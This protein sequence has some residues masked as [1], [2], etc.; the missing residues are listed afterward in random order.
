MLF[1]SRRM[2]SLAV[3]LLLLSFTLPALGQRFVRVFPNLASVLAS[4][5]SNADTNVTVLGYYTANDRGGSDITWAAGDATA[6]NGVTVFTSTHPTAQAGRWKRLYDGQINVLWSGAKRDNLTEVAT[7]WNNCFNVLSSLGGGELFVPVGTYFSA[8]T[9]G[10]KI[11]LT[12]SNIRVRAEPGTVISTHTQT[13]TSVAFQ[14]N[15]DGGIAVTNVQVSGITFLGATNSSGPASYGLQVNCDSSSD[16]CRDITISDCS[17]TLFATDGFSVG[18]NAGGFPRN[19][20]FNR[21]LAESNLRHGLGF[22]QVNGATINDS[23]FRFNRG[24][25]LGLSDGVDVEPDPGLQNLNIV[26]NRC[27]FNNNSSHGLDVKRGNG[28]EPLDIVVNDSLAFSNGGDGFRFLDVLRGGLYGSSGWSNTTHGVVL[29]SCVAFNV[30]GGS[31]YLNLGAGAQVASSRCAVS[32]ISAYS[33][34]THGIQLAGAGTSTTLCEFNTISGNFAATNTLNGILLGGAGWNKVQGNTVVFNQQEGL[35][36]SLSSQHNDIEDNDVD[37]NGQAGPDNAIDNIRFASNSSWNSLIGGHVRKS[38]RYNIGTA[39]GGGAASITLANGAADMDS[40]YV[41]HLVYTLSGT[42]SGQSRTISAYVGATRVAT[43]SLGW[44]VVPD[45]T[46][47]YEIAGAIRPRAGIGI[48]ATN[49]IGNRI[50]LSDAYYGGQTADLF[51]QGTSTLFLMPVTGDGFRVSAT[52]ANFTLEGGHF[53]VM[54]NYFINFLQPDGIYNP[55]VRM[56]GPH[57]YLQAYTGGDAYLRANAGAGSPAREIRVNALDGRLRYFSGTPL[58][59]QALN[60]SGEFMPVTVSPSSAFDTNTLTLT[61]SGGGATNAYNL[62]ED[63]GIALTARTTINFV[64]AGVSAADSGGKTV[65][66]ISGGGSGATINPTDGFLPYRFDATTFSNSP[67]YRTGASTVALSNLVQSASLTK[68]ITTLTGASTTTDWLLSDEFLLTLTADSTNTHSNVPSATATTRAVYLSVIGNGT[69]TIDFAVPGGITTNWTTSYVRTPRSGVT[70]FAFTSRGAVLDIAAS[71]DAYATTSGQVYRNSGTNGFGAIDLSDPDAVTGSLPA[72]SISGGQPYQLLRG[73]FDGLSAWDNSLLYSNANNTISAVMGVAKRGRTGDATGT[74][75]STGILGQYRFGGWN[76][77]SFV[78]GGGVDGYATENWTATANGTELRFNVVSNTTAVTSLAMTIGQDRKVKLESASTA[79]S[80]I[81]TDGNGFLV[82]TNAASGGG[83]AAEAW[84][85]IGTGTDFTYSGT[86]WERVAFGTSGPAFTLT[87][88]GTYQVIINL[89]TIDGSVA[90]TSQDFFVTNITDSV[91]VGGTFHST[92]TAPTSGD[93][94]LVIPFQI[95]TSGANRVIEVWGK[96]INGSPSNASVISTNT[97]LNVIRLDNLAGS[98]GSG[99]G[100][101]VGPSSA[102]DNAIVRFDGTTG[103]LGQNSLVTIGD[104]GAIT[105][106]DGSQTS[107]TFTPNLS[108]A[109]D[110]DIIFSNNLIT[111]GGSLLLQSSGVLGFGSRSE[112]V[113]GTDGYFTIRNEAG[114]DFEMLRFGGSTTAFPGL[115]RT[116]AELAVMLADESAFSALRASTVYVGPTN[117]AGELALKVPTATTITIAGTANE[118][119]SSAGA[120]DLSANRTWTLSLPATIDLGGKTSFELPNAAAPVVDA[121]G[122]IAGDDDLWAASRGAPVF[123]DGTA[124]VGLVGALVSDVPSNG[125]VPTW[126]TGGTITWETPAGGAGDNWGASGTTNSTLA[127]EAF[128]YDL[129]ATNNITVGGKIRAANGT[130][131]NPSILFT[132]DD[133]GS[134]NGF[135]RSAANRIGVSPAGTIALDFRNTGV[136]LVSGLYYAIN[137]DSY[138]GRE[139]AAVW[140]LGIDGASP[141]AQTIKGSDGGG[142]NIAGGDTTFGAGRSTGT[143]NRGTPKVAVGT[144][145]TGSGSGANAYGT[146]LAL[147]G[148]LKV[149]TTTTGNVD[150][151]EDDLISY[152][153]PAAQLSKDGDYFEFDVFGTFAANA[154]SAQ[155][156]F[157][158]DGLAFFDSTS[159]IFNGLT[160]RGTGKIIR[161]SAT[162][163]KI[164]GDF[165]ISGTLLGALTTTTRYYSADTSTLTGTIV[166][167]AT[168]TDTGG[169]PADNKVV[170]EGMILKQYLGQ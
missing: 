76:A 31:Y 24:H 162:T 133:D 23:I 46:T 45:A 36:V 29:T 92:Y 87:N 132:S 2:K 150:A 41:G 65:V 102:T 146:A 84:Q 27:T 62:V 151:G 141:T 18:G 52:P 112:I 47:T 9:V 77:S 114:T 66:T 57:A 160:W 123:F 19:V 89:S 117:V 67:I 82:I 61:V 140:Q 106:G 86:D 101:F 158:W 170:Q 120:Q 37:Q 70:V 25:A 26:F 103:K 56:S 60:G 147:G 128:L 55:T 40:Y 134:G 118:I 113:S 51:N 143:G 99:T 94:P 165:G 4:N 44:G 154:N 111:L 121:F 49:C 139:S 35:M 68:G 95:T 48:T 125:Q 98:G 34:A 153:I 14:I 5:P 164:Q 63:E 122:E 100:D 81:G 58:T 20:I 64:G 135:F 21:C 85:A 130:A 11:T 3:A 119:T 59:I 71:P 1:I 166:F 104:T 129:T 149:D 17:A 116:N 43:V 107:L 167:K 137:D 96:T 155:V 54:S 138:I 53:Q 91:V 127:G 161:T 13:A 22:I 32:G 12:N 93:A 75:A 38:T 156:K 108:G 152:T 115:Q 10:N 105:M 145:S 110:P 144:F 124:A 50:L 97:V 142:S 159:L 131:A 169:V 78:L 39:L 157:Y 126:N 148:T 15:A 83:G 8:G 73:N 88:A 80:Y 69:F 74:P 90:T 42:G 168:G 163:V 79:N 6:T 30:E 109:T 28:L 136:N 72:A 16:T 7:N 33:N